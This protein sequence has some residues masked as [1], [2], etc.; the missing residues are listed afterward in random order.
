VWSC[1][2]DYGSRYLAPVSFRY[3]AAHQPELQ[4][5]FDLRNVDVAGPLDAQQ[6]QLA[7]SMR[8]YWA[9]FAAGGAPSSESRPPWPAFD[10]DSRQ[11]L[12]LVPSGPH[13]RTD[14]GAEHHCGFWGVAG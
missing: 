1:L 6:E 2:S 3:G 5:L 12:S 11:T 9:N 10:G 8:G 4:H 13:A 7:A 14:F